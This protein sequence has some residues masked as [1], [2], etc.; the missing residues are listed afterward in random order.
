ML[1]VFLAVQ[2]DALVDAGV[3]PTERPTTIV[4]VV[5]G[6]AEVIRQGGLPIH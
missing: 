2:P 6:V 5:T 1:L 4:S 3:L